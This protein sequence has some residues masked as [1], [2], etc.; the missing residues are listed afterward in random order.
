MVDD[1]CWI[2]LREE[3]G[4]AIGNLSEQGGPVSFTNIVH[5]GARV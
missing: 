5:A 1:G 3:L 2:G 4:F